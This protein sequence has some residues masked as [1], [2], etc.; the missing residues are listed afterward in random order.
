M[1]PCLAIHKSILAAA[2][3]AAKI[4]HTTPLRRRKQAAKADPQDE[5]G[6]AG[7]G[8]SADERVQEI[9]YVDKDRAIAVGEGAEDLKGHIMKHRGAIK[10]TQPDE[11]TPQDL[12]TVL[13]QAAHELRIGD[14]EVSHMF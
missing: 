13:E 3:A 14:P 6:G 10:A 11:L 5:E 12:K 8:K 9:N 1:T 2:T 4:T 7:K